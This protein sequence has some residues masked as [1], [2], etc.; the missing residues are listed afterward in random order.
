MIGKQYKAHK[1]NVIDLFD[2]YKIKRGDLDDGIDI[3]FLENKVNS[4]K[5]NKFILAVAG[6][7]KA[8]K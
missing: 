5:N 6:E 4:L 1:E 3:K 7:V 8:G 2:N